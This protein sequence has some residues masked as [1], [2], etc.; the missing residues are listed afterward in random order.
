MIVGWRWGISDR[1]WGLDVVEFVMM[2][3]ADDIGG[4]GG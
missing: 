4:A 1:D 2:V 3:G